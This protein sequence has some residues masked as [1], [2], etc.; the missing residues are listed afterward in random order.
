MWSS[1]HSLLYVKRK[2]RCRYIALHWLLNSILGKSYPFWYTVRVK[3]LLIM[4]YKQKYS[5]LSSLINVIF[6]SQSFV[7][8]K[9]QSL[10]LSCC[11]WC[12]EGKQNL[13]QQDCII[14]LLLSSCW[15]HL[16]QLHY[17]LSIIICWY[18]DGNLLAICQPT[19]CRQLASRFMGDLF[20]FIPCLEFGPFILCL[21]NQISQQYCFLYKQ[22]SKL[23]LIL[24]LTV[25]NQNQLKCFWQD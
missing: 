3:E 7:C 19:V 25:L 14:W 1:C 10:K 5:Y 20:Y 15:L 16:C 22:L 23:W 12:T 2:Y 18:S 24:W 9:Q 11:F 4:S 8:E 21:W 6:M 13:F 17:V